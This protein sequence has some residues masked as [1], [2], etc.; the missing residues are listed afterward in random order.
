V[1]ITQADDR[2]GDGDTDENHIL[3]VYFGDKE[4][5]DDCEGS[6][7]AQIAST[8]LQSTGFQLTETGIATGVFTGTFQIPEKVCNDAVSQVATGLDIFTNYWDFR[9]VGG[10]EIEVGGAATVSANSGSVSLD[11]SVYP[12]IIVS[13]LFSSYL[14]L[15]RPI[16]M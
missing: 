12:L 8:G 7:N 6:G 2:V 4:F 16:L 13:P 5:D 14:L 15:N 1:Y 11:R 10:N 9:D 3:D